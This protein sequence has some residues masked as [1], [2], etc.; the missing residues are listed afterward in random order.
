MDRRIFLWLMASVFLLGSCTLQKRH[1]R[2]GYYWGLSTQRSQ[3][4]SKT[5]TRLPTVKRMELSPISLQPAALT[6]NRAEI[7]EITHFKVPHSKKSIIENL[8]RPFTKQ[9]HRISAHKKAFYVARMN[10]VPKAGFRM[11]VFSFLFFFGAW[12]LFS[13]FPDLVYIT[14][15]L[16]AIAVVFALVS[17][18]TSSNA[19]RDRINNSPFWLLMALVAIILDIL[20][21]CGLSLF[22]ISLF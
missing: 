6:S 13:L 4:V 11:M 18:I 8:T 21:L 14:V 5:L 2:S 10:H 3:S 15:G 19:R 20:I 7:R 9:M 22:L 17:L 16:L 12:F 1:Y